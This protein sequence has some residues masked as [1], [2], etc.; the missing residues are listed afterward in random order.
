MSTFFASVWAPDQEDLW[1]ID[2]IEE[3]EGVVRWI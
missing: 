1:G 3:L 2:G